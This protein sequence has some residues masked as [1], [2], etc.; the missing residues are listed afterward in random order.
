MWPSLIS[1][2]NRIRISSLTTILS[3]AFW[4]MDDW[5][6][7]GVINKLDIQIV[8]S[9]FP[10]HIFWVVNFAW[11]FI[12]WITFTK[13]EFPLLLYIYIKKDDCCSFISH[14]L[15]FWI[16]CYEWLN[17]AKHLAFDWRNYIM[18]LYCFLN[19]PLH[20]S[21]PKAIRIK[22]LEKCQSQH[23]SLI[24]QN[25]DLVP[26]LHRA[27]WWVQKMKCGGSNYNVNHLLKESVD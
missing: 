3:F 25:N 21:S 26:C 17:A 8:M 1:C 15:S 23:S 2:C 7:Q 10:C 11:D 18:P 14:D 22:L 6:L 20:L 12:R 9:D 16:R 19:R 27:L 4:N 24:S 13:I 5:H